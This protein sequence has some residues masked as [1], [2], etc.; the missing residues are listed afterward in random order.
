MTVAEVAD[1]QEDVIETV[2]SSVKT[3]RIRIWVTAA[4]GPIA[5]ITE[6]ELYN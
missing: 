3:D 6:I 4:N 5:K 1:K 2:F